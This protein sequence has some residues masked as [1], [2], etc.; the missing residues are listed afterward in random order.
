MKLKLILAMSV[1]LSAV[2]YATLPHAAISTTEKSTKICSLVN[3]TI[4]LK[5]P[6]MVDK[7]SMVIS[8]EVDLSERRTAMLC[9]S[10]KRIAYANGWRLPSEWKIQINSKQSGAMLASECA[11]KSTDLFG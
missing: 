9:G 8:F 7:S 6:C 10:I 1:I 3:D 11:Y 2:S 4:I 5:T